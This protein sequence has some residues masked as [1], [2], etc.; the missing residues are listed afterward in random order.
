MI[1]VN[2]ENNENFVMANSKTNIVIA[3]FTTA[4]TFQASGYRKDC[5]TEKQ[6]KQY[7]VEYLRMKGSE[8]DRGKIEHNLGM[9]ALAKLMLNSFGGV[10]N[11]PN[12]QISVCKN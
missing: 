7:V 3:A 2:Y 6:K 4:F 9:R 5:V 10:C 8:L 11:V 1:E 12:V